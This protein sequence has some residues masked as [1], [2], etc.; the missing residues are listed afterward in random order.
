MKLNKR[1][2]QHVAPEIRSLLIRRIVFYWCACLM[3]SILPLVIGT[4]LARPRELFTSHL[5]DLAL[6]F[7]PMF[8]MLFGIFPFLIRDALRVTNR[9]L[10]PIARLRAELH[11]YETTGAYSPVRCRKE[12]YLSDLITWINTAICSQTNAKDKADMEQLV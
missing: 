8:V 4:T 6:R 11:N 9:T 12:D 5:D 10:G 3:F 2:K 7:W 1:N